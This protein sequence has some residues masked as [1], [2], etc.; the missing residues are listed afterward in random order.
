MHK[1]VLLQEIIAGLDLKPGDTFLD[2][3]TNGGG[4]SEAVC[5]ALDGKVRIIGLDLDQEALS[6]AE[7][8]LRAC[9]TNFSG[10]VSNFRNLD[11]VLGQLKLKTVDKILF[12]LGWSSNQME[13]SG[14]GFSFQKDEPLLMTFKQKPEETDLTARDIVNQW[15]EENLATILF[16]YGEERFSRRIAK[17]L[18][19]ARKIK[20]IETTFDLVQIVK[21]ATPFAYHRGKIHFATRTFQALRIAVNDEILA[22]KEGLAKGYQALGKGGRMAVI[23][24]HSLEDRIVKNY[25]RD[26]AKVGMVALINKKPIIASREEVKDNPR[27][28]SA[29]LRIIE[30]L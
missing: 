18:V 13:A 30:K 19:E 11:Q 3:T 17:K 5:R 23:A 15:A 21:T 24:F 25:F 14:R 8:R 27:S 1:P 29:K 9:H 4:H 20:P 22:L 10:H 6:K 26:L 2:C 28:R 16:S 12:D 7:E